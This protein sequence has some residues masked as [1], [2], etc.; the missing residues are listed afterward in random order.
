MKIGKNS[1]S[2]YACPKE[3][4][5]TTVALVRSIEFAFHLFA[6]LLLIGTVDAASQDP[7]KPNI[8]F[9]LVDDMG[10]QDTSVPFWRDKDGKPIRTYLNARYHT[11]NMEKLAKKG[12]IFTRAYASSI[13]SPT[14]CSL[15]SGMNAA[16]HRVT[17][18]TL[19]CDTSTDAAHKA[20]TPPAWAV[21][22]LQPEHTKARGTTTR[23]ITG[24]H[25]EYEMKRP[26][27][28]CTP[29]PELLRQRGYTTIHCGKAHWG[30]RD[31][32]GANPTNFGFDYNIAGS[33]IGGPG[34]YLG[35]E[36]Y[37][38]NQFHVCGLDENNYYEDDVFLTEAITREALSRL[39]KL[40][41][42][43]KEKNK[44]FYLYMSQY[45]VHAPLDEGDHR[46]IEHYDDPQDGHPWSVRERNYSTLIEGMDRS[47]GDLMKWLEAHQLAESTVIIFMADNGGLALSSSARTG[48]RH[49]NFPL[50]CG[51]GSLYEGGIR[52][53]M[54]TYW[55]GVT[56]AGTVNH[57]PLIVEDFFPTLLEIADCRKLPPTKQVVDGRSFVPALR[58]EYINTDRPLVFHQPNIWGE[59][60]GQ[61]V[62]YEPQSALICGDWKLIYRHINQSFELYNIA[63]DI[64]E[65]KNLVAEMPGKVR[66]LAKM[67]SNALEDH[68]A[69]MPIYKP[70]NPIGAPTGSPVPLPIHSPNLP[71]TFP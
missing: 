6:A 61:G 56:K 62:G 27:T 46:F 10:W 68:A 16:R 59:G 53:P 25:Y 29:L 42:D 44:P 48:D 65:E 8:I 64:G 31:T 9:F 33:E 70:D 26:F 34:S 66:E 7:R 47:L 50:F 14:R 58:G 36:H 19:Q 52:E 67:L 39:S 18:W 41:S 57:S 37:G 22:G 3:L 40:N 15:M 54:I 30:S 12:M 2:E 23:P 21:N 5:N 69:Q 45:A 55:P 60:N 28:A 17:N 13:C 24:E 49:A 43:P 32:P 38:N 51:K 1:S 63:Y 11:P 20:V 35:K 4:V 71:R